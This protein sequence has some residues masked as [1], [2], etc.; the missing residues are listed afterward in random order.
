[1]KYLLVFL[2]LM[3]GCISPVK[4]IDNIIPIKQRDLPQHRTIDTVLKYYFTDEAYQAVKDIPSVDALTFGGSYVAGVNFW[5]SL[6]AFFTRLGIGRKVVFSMKGLSLNGVPTVLH[7]YF[8]HI[9]DMTRDGDIDLV[10]VDEFE[11]AWKR[12]E[13]E[14][15][16]H[17]GFI[18]GWADRIFTNLFGIGE[19]SEHMGYTL[20]HMMMY[21]GPKYMKNV[22]RKVIRNWK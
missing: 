12:L 3:S 14:F 19:Y 15:P 18:D 11:V 2:L 1:M 21:G 17:A 5:T 8:H 9:D 16:R 4:R 7:E 13:K 6:Y 22:Y 10:S 20:Q